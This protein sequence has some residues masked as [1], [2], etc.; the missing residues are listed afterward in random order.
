MTET[1]HRIL[2][3]AGAVV[4]GIAGLLIA[5]NL[6]NIE[7]LAWIVVGGSAATLSGNQIRVWWPATATVTTVTTTGTSPGSTDVR[8]TFPPP[9]IPPTPS[10]APPPPPVTGP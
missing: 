9:S 1:L 6:V 7:V 10:A 4:T 2:M 5:A 8:Q 3:F